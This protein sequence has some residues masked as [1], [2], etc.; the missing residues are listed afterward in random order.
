MLF[1]EQVWSP[2]T[3]GLSARSDHVGSV[4]L[5][6]PQGPCPPCPGMTNTSQKR[7][8]A[9]R[10]PVVHTDRLP[11]RPV[12][13]TLV[14]NVLSPWIST[15]PKPRRAQ[16]LFTTLVWL[17]GIYK[18]VLV[19]LTLG[20]G[21]KKGEE[22]GGVFSTCLHHQ[23]LAAGEE[24]KNACLHLPPAC[25][26]GRPCP[27]TQDVLYVGRCIRTLAFGT[28]KP[29]HGLFCLRFFHTARS[30]RSQYLRLNGAKSHRLPWSK[31]KTTVIG[32]ETLTPIGLHQ[33]GYLYMGSVV[34]KHQVAK[35]LCCFL[36]SGPQA[37]SC[38]HVR[39]WQVLLE[40]SRSRILQAQAET[41]ETVLLAESSFYFRDM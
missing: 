17:G 6:R 9:P 14:N 30:P 22:S 28:S 27:R 38:Q 26:W 21:R 33:A 36:V 34:Q 16:L 13:R 19:S 20:P 3:G 7:T 12:S 37:V 25:I 10:P 35:W 24:G 4:P 40:C 15:F 8:G 23:P 1:W 2:K 39:V 5:G 41:A 29:P 11:D 31:W 32:R 18:K